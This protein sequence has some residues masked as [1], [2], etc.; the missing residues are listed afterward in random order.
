MT[1]SLFDS[2]PQPVTQEAP[3]VALIEQVTPPR[4]DYG[5]NVSRVIEHKNGPFRRV[6]EGQV[7]TEYVIL[8]MKNGVYLQ[9]TTK[10]DR[11]PSPWISRLLVETSLLSGLWR[12]VK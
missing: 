2:R 3:A 5:A 6:L 8:E 1:A 11:Y 9:E 4:R 10:G 7:V 12:E